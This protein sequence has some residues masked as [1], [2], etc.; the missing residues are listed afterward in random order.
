M[1]EKLQNLKSEAEKIISIAKNNEDLF[2]VEKK[3]L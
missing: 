2:E 3:F 1:L